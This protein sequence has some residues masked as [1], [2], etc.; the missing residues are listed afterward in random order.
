M[1]HTFVAL[2]ETSRGFI[3]VDA[4]IPETLGMLTREMKKLGLGPKELLLVVVTHVHYDHVGNLAAIRRMTGA[5]VLVHAAEKTSL[6]C[7]ETLVPKGTNRFSKAVAAILGSRAAGKRLFEPVVPDIVIDA[8]FDLSAFGVPGRAVP[9]PGHTA[10]SLSVI[11]DSGEA[12]VG[13]ACW[14]VG[15]F[16]RGTVFPPF[17]S[18]VEALG[19]SWK[20]LLDS[21]AGTFHP[22]H[23]RPFARAKLLESYEKKFG[24]AVSSGE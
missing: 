19:R 16:S 21:G 14:N 18:D 23:G 3:L 7:A 11:L 10:G 2:I 4:G 17:A 13:D 1:G 22:G 24:S 6:E 15:P 12:F 8:G 5:E 9:T 20:L